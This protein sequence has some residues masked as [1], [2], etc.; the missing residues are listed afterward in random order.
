MAPQSYKVLISNVAVNCFE[1][2]EHINWLHNELTIY[3]GGL[4]LLSPRVLIFLT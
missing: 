4:N 1:D 3:G 2:I